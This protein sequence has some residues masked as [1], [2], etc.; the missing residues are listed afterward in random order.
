MSS[1]VKSPTAV[2]AAGLAL[3]GVAIA[4]LCLLQKRK[5]NSPV[6]KPAAVDTPPRVPI[7]RVRE[8][9]DLMVNTGIEV[10]NNIE[11]GPTLYL[12]KP[13]PSRL[14]T[15]KDT[16]GRVFVNLPVLVTRISRSTEGDQC[17]TDVAPTAFTVFQRY[18]DNVEH[19]MLGGQPHDLL[20]EKFL[21]LDDEKPMFDKLSQLLAGK[22]LKFNTPMLYGDTDENPDEWLEI[23]IKT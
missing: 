19:F 23:Q 15:G 14:F 4:T 18:T 9:T 5:A 17:V 13:V 10:D 12:D 21:S 11:I 7:D 8:L 16:Y 6:S 22:T 2:L 1:S 3:G 20:G